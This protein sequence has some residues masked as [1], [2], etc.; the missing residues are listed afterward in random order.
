MSMMGWMS[1][2]LE[3]QISQS[4]RG[5]FINQSKYAYEIVKKYDMLSSDSVDTPLVDKSKLD[6]DLQEKPVDATL[7]CGMIGSLMYLTFSRSELT[8]AVCL[9]AQYQAKP[10]EKHLNAAQ[11]RLDV[12]GRS[13]LMMGISNEHQL[14]FNSIRDA[15]KLLEAVEKRFD[16]MEE[17]DLRWKM[18]MLTMRNRRSF[19]KIGSKLTV[20]GNKTI[21]FDKSNKESYNCHKRRHFV[22]ECRDIRNQD[23][24]HKESSRRSVLVET[25]AFIAL[26]SCDGLGGYD[27]SDQAEEGPNNALMAFSSSSSNS[28][29]S[30]DYT[31]SKSCFKTVKLLKSLNDQLLIDLKKSELMVLAISELRKKLE[32]AQKEKDVIQLNVD[33]FEHASKSLNKLIDCQIV[34]NCKKGLGYENYNAVPPPYTGIFMPLTPDLF[35]IGLDEFVN[36]PI[37]EN[38]KAKSSEEEPKVVKKSHDAPNIEEWVSDNKEE[39]VSQPKIEKKTVRPSIIKT[40]FFK[41]KKQ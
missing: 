6:E 26:V 40:E 34:D 20:N 17:M 7:Y 9:C 39:D 27:Q 33:K 37:V 5:I 3:L 10:I 13:T 32:I 15:K 2:F 11:R 23:N 16:D 19:N 18:A 30:N 24:K 22:R 36:K 35:F 28:E 29:V 12:K 38:C 1:F 14:K 8:Y 25:S 4:P 31:C 21:G 41:S